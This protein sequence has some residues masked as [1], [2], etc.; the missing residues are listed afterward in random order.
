MS[1]TAHD[2]S[3]YG[4]PA[5]SARVVV[6]I[7]LIVLVSMFAGVALFV[8]DTAEPPRAT[9]SLVDIAPDEAAQIKNEI[10]TSHSD[11]DAFLQRLRTLAKK[12]DMAV[13]VGWTTVRPG[14]AVERIARQ[15]IRSVRER[16]VRRQGLSTQDGVLVLLLLDKPRVFTLGGS[17][18]VADMLSASVLYQPEFHHLQTRLIKDGDDAIF[19]TIDFIDFQFENIN[20]FVALSPFGPSTFVDGFIDFG[21][22]LTEML[23]SLAVELIQRGIISLKS[24]LDNNWA[25]IIAFPAIFVAVHVLTYLLS[26][27]AVRRCVAVCLG[28]GSVGTEP[29][30]W[31]RVLWIV[32]TITFEVAMM[33]LFVGFLSIFIYG[34]SADVLSRITYAQVARVDF[35]EVWNVSEMAR[36]LDLTL[37]LPW[38]VF[39]VFAFSTWLCAEFFKLF[40]YV[41]SASLQPSFYGGGE[42]PLGDWQTMVFGFVLR[43]FGVK[44]PTNAATRPISRQMGPVLYLTLVLLLLAL[45]VVPTV[46]FFSLVPLQGPLATLIFV[47]LLFEALRVLPL[48]RRSLLTSPA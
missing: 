31:N 22:S 5:N 10:F 26:W 13:G 37:P 46:L 28:N 27:Q 39:L 43:R 8:C 25:L 21:Q 35:I 17:G 1:N 3:Q 4:W 42:A 6:R 38:R 40:R 36:R 11:Y 47:V 45:G 2:L 33:F 16:M 14:E 34:L 29:H 20:A 48:L 24:T 7:A 18:H 9:P 15:K 23:P 32:V 44:Q 19:R 41:F 12:H 30:G